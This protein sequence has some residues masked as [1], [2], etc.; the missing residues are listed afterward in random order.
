MQTP[1][2]E[3]KPSS[4]RYYQ[5]GPPE[6]LDAI[7]MSTWTLKVFL[8]Y[9]S[10]PIQITFE[11]LQNIATITENRRVVC[12]CNW[13]IRRNWTGILL[14]DLFDYL[15][16]NPS[17]YRCYNL[18]QLSLGTAK[19]VYDSTIELSNAFENRAMIIWAIDGAA[20][21]LE[22]GY[23]IR[24]VDFSLYRYKGVKCLSELHITDELEQGYWEGKAG[25]CKTGKIKPKRYRIVDLQEHRFID[26][27]GEVTEF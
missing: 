8:P 23:P 6:S 24:L 18:K 5:E 15:G 13:S 11:E 3:K 16:I 27:T 1:H 25:Y 14:E 7:D 19:G 12:V 20:L 22:E 26:G 2:I 17:K 9:E 21:S 4:L 10:S